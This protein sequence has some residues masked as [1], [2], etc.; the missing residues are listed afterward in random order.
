MMD[1]KIIRKIFPEE[2][3]SVIFNKST[4]F[5]AR[6]EKKGYEEPF[7]SKNSPELL[8]ISITNYCEKNCS[9]CYRNS[10]INGNHISL[11][12]YNLIIKQAKEIGVFQVALGGGNPNQHPHFVEILESTF[13][14]GIVP[15]YTTNGDGLTSDILL[16]TK[17]YC[18]AMALSTYKPYENLKSTIDRIKSFGIKL[19]IHF[20]LDKNTI[21]DAI[22]WLVNPPDFL[23]Q[24]NAIIFL[25]YKPINSSN[26][27]L[28][29][30]SPRLKEFFKLVNKKHTFKIGFDS[31]SVSGIV[32]EM[33]VNPT[34]FESCEA[35]KFSAFIS[36]DMKM[37]PCSFMADTELFADLRNN[38][39]IDIWQNDITFK[40]FRDKIRNNNC[41]DCEYEKLCQGGCLFIPDIN[42]CKTN[43]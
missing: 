24:I 28:L 5:F 29:R 32:K 2:N 17:K 43:E 12:D 37:F 21:N 42:L 19:N 4:G 6:I 40:S 23:N 13:K 41:K 15:S 11:G 35:A 16:A 1:G 9:F 7:W 10:N 22:N 36:E 18:G 38:S 33:D 34:Y 26:E 8:D 31:C 30:K 14:S 20:L 39:I 27:Q 25:N 3:Y